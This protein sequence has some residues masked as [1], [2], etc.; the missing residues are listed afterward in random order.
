MYLG[1]YDAV[2]LYSLLTICVVPHGDRFEEAEFGI[3]HTLLIIKLTPSVF[4]KYFIWKPQ[5]VVSFWTFFYNIFRIRKNEMSLTFFFLS[6]SQ[7]LL[8]SRIHRF[9]HLKCLRFYRVSLFFLWSESLYLHILMLSLFESSFLFPF[10]NCSFFLVR[11]KNI[12]L[13]CQYFTL[14]NW[15][16]SSS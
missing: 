14:M 7:H 11:L 15:V 6:F 13:R 8:L 12:V 10:I 16:C 4:A 9:N 5:S 1:I 3:M 2:S